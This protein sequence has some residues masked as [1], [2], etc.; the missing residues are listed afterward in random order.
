MGSSP[1]INIEVH[2]DF[3]SAVEISN[4]LCDWLGFEIIDKHIN[5]KERELGYELKWDD[6]VPT[7]EDENLQPLKIM[8]SESR[9]EYDGS[10]S[11]EKLLIHY[12]SYYYEDSI[13]RFTQKS[14]IINNILSWLQDNVNDAEIK[15]YV[16][17]STT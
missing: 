13:D 2:T 1:T 6:S 8:W 12:S 17:V 9:N 15:D 4:N 14:I 10:G 7:G 16:A 3:E 11:G 5:E